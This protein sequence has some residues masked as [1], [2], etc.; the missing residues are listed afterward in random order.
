MPLVCVM[1]KHISK[2]YAVYFF[3]YD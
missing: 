3:E 2:M 1:L